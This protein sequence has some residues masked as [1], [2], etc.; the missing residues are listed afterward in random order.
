MPQLGAPTDRRIGYCLSMLEPSLILSALIWMI[1]LSHVKW[2]ITMVAIML[3]D[4]KEV[5]ISSCWW[6]TTP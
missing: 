3:K 1:Q 6:S 4:L 5:L 2:V